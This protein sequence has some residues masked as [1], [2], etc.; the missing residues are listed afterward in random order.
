MF[1]TIFCN[2]NDDG[3][4]SFLRTLGERGLQEAFKYKG[5]CIM[6]VLQGCENEDKNGYTLPTTLYIPRKVIR[7]T[8]GEK[9]LR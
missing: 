9:W 8:E 4:D 5:I 2:Y 1:G 7:N 3:D 6:R